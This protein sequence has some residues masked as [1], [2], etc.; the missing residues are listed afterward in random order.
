[1]R[2]TACGICGLLL[3]LPASAGSLD[4]WQSVADPSEVTVRIHWASSAEIKAAARKVGKR[5]ETK[6]LGFSVL[7]LVTAT[8]S[9]VCDIYLLHRPERVLDRATAT[10]GHEMAHC[11]GFSH[12]QARK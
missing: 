7:R 6:A 2:R 11:L 1:M 8:G 4:V 10:L 9:Y 3:A 5:S 12:E